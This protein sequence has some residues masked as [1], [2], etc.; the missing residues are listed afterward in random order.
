MESTKQRHHRTKV[1]K[2]KRPV[3]ENHQLES[4]DFFVCGCRG[5]LEGVKPR[6]CLNEEP[7]E[8]TVS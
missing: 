5:Y 6:L 1:H 3:T 2:H 7:I 8:S 4:M